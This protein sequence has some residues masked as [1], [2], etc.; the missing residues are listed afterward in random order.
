MGYCSGMWSSWCH[1]L[2]DLC[3]AGSV[4]SVNEKNPMRTLPMARSPARPPPAAPPRRSVAAR[5]GP[6]DTGV[7]PPNGVV[8]SPGLGLGRLRHDSLRNQLVHVP[9]EL[10]AGVEHIEHPGLRDV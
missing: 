2:Y 5:L 1:S 7:G 4:T 10:G 8:P 6:D 3:S 9:R